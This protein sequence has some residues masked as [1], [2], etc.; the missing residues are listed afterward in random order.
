M[1]PQSF[2]QQQERRRQHDQRVEKL[3]EDMYVGDGKNNPSMTNRMALV[4]EKVDKIESNLTWI[5]RLMIASVIATVLEI[6]AQ[7]WKH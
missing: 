6:I 5:T 7:L 2:D 1:T 4:E 3:Y